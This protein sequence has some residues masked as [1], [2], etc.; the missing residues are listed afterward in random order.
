[1]KKTTKLIAVLSAAA[2]VSMA[3]P[4]VL[5]DSFLLNAWAA[6]SGWVQEDNGWHFYDEDG[7][8]ESNTW[9]KKRKRLVLP[10]RRW[11]CNRER[12]G[13]RILCGQ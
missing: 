11:K 6:E 7:Y 12:A 9:K 2:M 1:M 10:G 13:R 4:D 5:N 3:A 8:L